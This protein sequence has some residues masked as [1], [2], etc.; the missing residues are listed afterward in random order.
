MPRRTAVHKDAF[1]GPATERHGS[2]TLPMLNSTPG[3]VV[4]VEFQLQLKQASM[5]VVLPVPA[6]EVTLTGL[7]PVLQHFTSGVAQ[8][9][10]GVA[11]KSG[12]PVTCGPKCGACCRQMVP[13]SS[14]EAEFLAT[15]IRSL[16]VEEQSAL[17]A[18][19]HEALL[20]LQAKGVLARLTPEMFELPKE[21]FQA[22]GQEYFTA[23]VACP[24]LVDESCSIHPIRPLICREYMVV[25]PP[26]FCAE[27]GHRN[28]R[29]VVLPVRP[30]R[31]LINLSKRAEGDAQGWLP[32]VYLI[33]WM[34]A[35]I[36]PGKAI[37]GPGPEVLREFVSAL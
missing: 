32:L 8:H 1:L 2:Y 3:E 34:T 26:E 16:P 37:S 24:F 17:A 33:S 19:F 31:A 36:E 4:D 35:H 10:M 21:Q 28:A 18:R 6:G 27:P 14:F 9:M 25:T 29:G 13:I 7:L 20:Q 22:L 30:S 12:E 23:W 15:W 11:E 5:R